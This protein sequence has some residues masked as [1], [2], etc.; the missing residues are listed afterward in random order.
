M[1]DEIEH[2]WAN[3]RGISRPHPC[4]TLFQ[5]HDVPVTRKKQ[6][7]QQ[8]TA[9]VVRWA[10]KYFEFAIEGKTGVHAVADEEHLCTLFPQSPL[11]VARI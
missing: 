6:R 1:G 3:I 8:I 7:A 11:R 9:T 10:C 2:N 4:G 5:A